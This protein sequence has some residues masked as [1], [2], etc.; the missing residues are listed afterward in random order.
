[1]IVILDWDQL[2]SDKSLRCELEQDFA[3]IF[4]KG[5]LMLRQL[6]RRYKSQQILVLL[7]DE[8]VSLPF[9]IES[10][11][12][13]ISWK[14]SDVFPRLDPRAL[15]RYPNE[16]FQEI[17]EVYQVE[18][19]SLARLNEEQAL[20]VLREWVREG[21]VNAREKLYSHTEFSYFNAR[22]GISESNQQNQC[23]QL[24]EQ[25]EHLS[26]AE[27]INWRK[28]AKMYGRLE[29]LHP[30]EAVDLERYIAF[31]IT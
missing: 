21:K 12:D 5:E 17:Y 11:A 30:T 31:E 7:Q 19:A 27:E 22:S 26:S 20:L 23:L 9:D 3:V 24:M 29:A 16:D 10:N 1:M 2:G 28:I 4:F 6:I 8:G 25:I 14:L 18:E 15:K 13:V